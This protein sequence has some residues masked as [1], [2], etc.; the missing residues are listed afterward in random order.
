MFVRQFHRLHPAAVLAAMAVLAGSAFA[1]C[2]N[3]EIPG[4]F[5]EYYIIAQTGN[6][7]GNNFTS[8]GSNPSINDLTQVGFM[9]QTSALSG[10]ALFVGDGHMNPA[11]TPINP[12]EIGSSEIY[13]GAVQ[14]GSAYPGAASLV[15]KDSIT[16]TSPAT[17]SIRVWDIETPDSYRYAAR[18]GPGQQFAA[19]FAYPSVN[20]NGDVAFIALDQSN[21]TIKYLVE[22]LA[23]GTL[24]KTSVAVSV[25]EPMID[26]NGE[27]LLYTTAPSIVLY[28][29][30]LHSTTMIADGTNFTSI[31]SAPGISRDG[32]VIAFQ[33]NLSA[34]G[35]SA[36]S[37]YPG[38]GIFAAW[39][40]SSGW[41]TTQATGFQVNTSNTNNGNCTTSQTCQPAAELGFDAA[42]NAIYF[43]PSGYGVGTRVAVTN[44][45]L[46]AAG[47]YND[48]FVVSFIGTP[49]EAS[50]PNPV[51]NNGTPL[52][53]SAQQG[54]WTIRVDVEPYLGL[55]G[56]IS[57][58]RTAIP[59]V[60]IGDQIGSNV[61]ASLSAFDDLANAA[62]D[63]TTGDVRTMRRGDHRV[64]F[65]ASTTSGGQMIVRANHL[66]SDQDGLLD[67]WET[68]GIDMDHDGVVD[69]NLQAMGADVNVR[70]LFVEVDWIAKQ[71]GFPYSFEPAPGVISPAP[72]Q[73][74]M[75][76]LQEMYNNAPELTGNDYGVRIDGKAAD[77]IPQGITLH[78]DGGSGKDQAGNPFSVNMGTGPLDGGSQIGLTGNGSTGLPEVMY[79][80]KP[81]SLTIPG[82]NTRAFQDVKD[83]YFGSQDKDGR[84]LAFHY[85]VL[86]DYFGVETDSA[87]ANS[88]QVSTAGANVLTSASPL[89]TSAQVGDIVKITGG[90]GVGQY[91]TVTDI[92]N[93]TTLQI[94][95]N[96]ATDPDH[97]STFSLL[98]GN[99]GL[100][101]VYFWPSPDANSLPGNDLMITMGAFAVPPDTSPNGLLG[102]PCAQW[103]T[104][105]H[106]LGHTL[107]LRHGGTNFNTYQGTSYLSLMSYS[108]VLECNVFSQVQSYSGK[109]DPTFDDWANLQHNF[110]DSE[111]HL[112]N[113]VGLSFGTYPEVELEAPELNAADYVSINGSMGAPPTVA[114]TSP[115]A[116]ANEGL[117]L[118][119]HVTVNATDSQAIGSVTVSF[120]VNGG[121]TPQLI[122]AKG[123]G[124]TY[125]ANFPALSGPAGSRKLTASAIDSSGYSAT[126]SI[127]VNVEATNPVPSLT[128][129][130]PPSATHGGKA[131]T[132]TV[133]GSN[134]V[135][136]STVDWNG[137]GVSTSF[138]NSGQ[139]TAKITAA[140]IA[141]AGSATV[142]VKN[143]APGGGTSNSLTFTIN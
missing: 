25:G 69:L 68:T 12:G 122:V 41:I 96:W 78:V 17:T 3:S 51:L 21:P 71:S 130:S 79:F 119:L 73:G 84:E 121:G 105:A 80:G 120:D 117:T 112:G 26:D 94:G 127:N 125:T 64:A 54:L 77:P 67:H 131:F 5:Y 136:G 92:L 98:L 44:L 14:I 93:S 6:C 34:A 88:W 95:Q 4:T 90:T 140:D 89:P 60:Q 65:W 133:N 23:D 99:T 61:V 109:D 114:I 42:G 45:E 28:A 111:L 19:V 27:V 102:T 81:N 53:F 13:D 132:L 49:S 85:V 70:D 100:A 33:G 2:T 107:G 31:D 123:S 22:V 104:M 15:S 8:L 76:F 124:S 52:L 59:V 115:K 24:Y 58:A 30:G 39:K 10:T 29:K 74:P 135:S 138:V 126:T 72:G 37:L 141:A 128:S 86:A 1:Q 83:N 129:L 11:T 118:P 91:Q 75:G 50:R 56:Y 7:N 110:S 97:T 18:G 35:E 48:S 46:G 40:S 101:E 108:W 66:D 43:N 143:P 113:S 55:N 16:T 103:R 36:L 32:Y 87:K 137:K 139:V 62:L 116:N 57:H 142:T 38:P 20:K 134:F 47:I 9:A 63:E 82:V 106:E